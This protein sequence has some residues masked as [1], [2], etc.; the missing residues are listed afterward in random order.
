MVQKFVVV[1][2]DEMVG[3]APV[4]EMLR[5]AGLPGLDEH[6]SPAAIAASG[7]PIEQYVPQVLDRSV[8]PDGV[9]A[10]VLRASDAAR[11]PFRKRPHWAGP[12]PG[13]VHV[14]AADAF[15]A[16][17]GLYLEARAGAGEGGPL[18][19]ATARDALARAISQSGAAGFAGAP[20]GLL[21]VDRGELEARPA[22]ALKRIL[23]FAGLDEAAAASAEAPTAPGR[24]KAVAAELR[25]LAGSGGPAPADA[26]PSARVALA[27]RV[28]NEEDIVFQNLAW[29]F[30]SGLRRFLIVDQ[31]STDSTR[32][33]IARFARAC[34]PLG[35]RIVVLDDPEPADVS[36]LKATAAARAAHTC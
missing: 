23:A 20:S 8:G 27:M 33:E 11:F 28:R 10:T 36:G 9:L 32:A 5:R 34:E 13:Y 3:G 21:Q 26:D 2:V 7:L 22:D 6:F 17:A 15:E 30:A 14:R 16:A 4:V 19:L 18:D 1:I 29:H 25:A 12:A 31:A 35:A 24:L